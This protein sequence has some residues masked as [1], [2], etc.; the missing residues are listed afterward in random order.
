MVQLRECIF[1]EML[2]PFNPF[3][4]LILVGNSVESYTEE[5]KKKDLPINTKDANNF[6]VD[7]GLKASGN[8]VKDR[9]MGSGITPTTNEI[10]DIIKVIRSL[11]NR[12]NFI[13][14]DY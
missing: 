3:K 11:E 6:L 9:L 4:I 5:L 7:A 8:E 1:N 12:R 13:E 14:R 2:G 10:K